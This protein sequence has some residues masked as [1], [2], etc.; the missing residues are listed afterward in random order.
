MIPVNT[1][2]LDGNEKKYLNECIDTGWIS[3]EGPFVQQFESAI[4]TMANRKYGV[5]VSSGSAA[6]DCALLALDL[7]PNSEI[8][9]P[10][11][12]IISCVSS[13]VRAGYKPV[14]IDS[15]PASWNMDISKLEE[16]IT[17]N[18]SAIMVVHIYG[19]PVDMNPVLAMAKKH[20][21]KVI[22]D[23]AEQHGQFYFDKAIGSFGDVSIFSFYPNKNITTGE[24]GMIVT[25]DEDIAHKCRSLRNLCFEPAKRFYH[26]ELGFNY[27]MTNVQAAIGVAQAEQLERFVAKRREIGYYYHEH[28]KDIKGIQL[29]LQ[30]T[31]FATNIYWVFGIVLGPSFKVDA[32][33]VMRQLGAEG[34][35]TR[36]FFYPMHAQPVFKKMGLFTNENYPVSEILAE[37]GF[38][39][40]SGLGIT[41]QEQDIVINKLRA[42]LTNAENVGND[43]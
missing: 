43:I 31:D 22:E 18:T 25:D 39:I 23:A 27:R 21:L 11:F 9:A 24:G 13:I 29:P 35:G 7:Q 20:G 16:K 41:R 30:A 34:I 19:L 4:A 10:T 17:P 12:T 15:E 37:R 42:I 33:E 1:P 32:L 5:A 14:L 28:L 8:I 40:P 3:S 2:L 6:L 36:P 38:Y 26:N